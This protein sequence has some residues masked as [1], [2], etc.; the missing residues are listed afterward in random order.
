MCG[1][2]MVHGSGAVVSLGDAAYEGDDIDRKKPRLQYRRFI[3][4]SGN[5]LSCAGRLL[6]GSSRQLCPVCAL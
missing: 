4:V 1:D 5:A 6:D 3:V 2:R